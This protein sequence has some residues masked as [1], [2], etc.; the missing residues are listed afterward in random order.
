MQVPHRSISPARAGFRFR[1]LLSPFLLRRAAFAY[2]LLMT[3]VWGYLFWLWIGGSGGRDREGVV[4]GPDFPL[5]YT[6]G[7]IL[8]AHAP[9]RLY[10]LQL[11]Q[12][13]QRA[14]LDSEVLSTYVYPPHWAIA[15]VPFSLL[16]Y[17]HAWA[18][19][20]VLMAVAVVGSVALL[21]MIL[22][23]LR[24]RDGRLI[25]G[26]AIGAAPV[27]AAFSAGQNSG[28]SLVLHTGILVALVQR[29][30][31]LAGV[32]LAC[33][34][35]KPQLFAL[36]LPL[37]LFDR[38]W[39]ALAAWGV[40]MAVIGLVTWVVFGLGS[41]GA[42]ID[43]LRSPLFQGEEVNQAGKYFSWQPFWILLLGHSAGASLLA[44]VCMVL[45][46]VGLIVIWR[47][48]HG[49]LPLR[50]G[51]TICGLLLFGPHTPVYDLT[52][53]L[54]PGLVI[55]DRVLQQPRH[56]LISLRL[57]LLG[58]YVLLL[59]SAADQLR[60][61][62]VITPLLAALMIVAARCLPRPMRAA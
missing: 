41:I 30:D 36:I 20:I 1:L 10:D 35:Y 45:T 38:R 48:D 4:L 3:F 29:R 60:P 13:I 33:G 25:I 8:R 42:W 39:R 31:G 11:Q 54:I 43:L 15:G 44:Y 51:L 49:D 27:Y 18:L 58:L 59:F 40:G 47:R 14:V 5:F 21:R 57:L 56:R 9:A 55:L 34:M 52:L 6:G 61:A 53:L 24:G 16:T 23:S 37:L 50:Y 19:W 17:T 2:L 22:P 28:L 7:L 12:S 26:L 32:L 46:L 62:L